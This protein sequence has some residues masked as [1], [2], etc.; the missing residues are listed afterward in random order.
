MNVVEQPR[1][2][3]PILIFLHGFPDS[4]RLWDAQLRHFAPAAHLVCLDLAAEDCEVEALTQQV[5]AVVQRLRREHPGRAVH[6][7]GHDLGCFILNEVCL[8]AP[9]CVDGQVLINGAGIAQFTSRLGGARAEGSWSQI[10]RSLYVLMLNLP[11]V[12][13]LVR[14]LGSRVSRRNFGP[15]MLYRALSRRAWSRL[16]TEDEARCLVPTVLISGRRDPFLVVPSDAEV[17]RFF[18]RA[19]HVVLGARHWSPLT[20]PAD[21]N[22]VIATATFAARSA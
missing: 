14:A 13:A 19:S 17:R 15:I 2:E 3:G 12:A 11:G 16:G 6:L 5:L 18:A 4:S 9:E 22:D 21:V 8:R 1:A 20:H 7:V 10:F